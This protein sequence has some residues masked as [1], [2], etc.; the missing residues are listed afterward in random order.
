MHRPVSILFSICTIFQSCASLSIPSKRQS[1]PE[2]PSG[3]LL[4]LDKGRS[5]TTTGAPENWHPSIRRINTDGTSAQHVYDFP[6]NGDASTVLDPDSIAHDPI[7]NYIF[8]GT[9]QGVYRLKS[10]GSDSAIIVQDTPARDISVYGEKVY[11]ISGSPSANTVKRANFD[12]SNIELVFEPKVPINRF[13]VDILGNLIYWTAD[14]GEG[15]LPGTISRASLDSPSTT[16]LLITNLDHPSQIFS[17]GGYV[18][19]IE[20]GPNVIR[21]GGFGMPGSSSILSSVQTV[22][23]SDQSPIFSAPDG[24]TFAISAF[25]VDEERERLW[26]GIVDGGEAKVVG[27]GVDGGDFGVVGDE[28]RDVG[29]VGGLEFVRGT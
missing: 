9:Q 29:I 5:N 6:N 8:I 27:T 28:A 4:I 2:K 16:E 1:D 15:S 25:A 22:V 23:R 17:L 19:W 18:Y 13:T 24:R 20:Q 14:N 3:H 12:G 11:Y 10:N 21:R 26:F 7:N